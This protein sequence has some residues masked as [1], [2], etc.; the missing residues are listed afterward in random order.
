MGLYNNIYNFFL[1]F[2][3]NSAHLIYGR[4][5]VT[6]WVQ[7]VATEVEHPLKV[8]DVGCGDGSDLANLQVL[9]KGSA[10][11]YGIEI[12]PVMRKSCTLRGIP[13]AVI[14]IEKEMLPFPDGWLD[15]VILNQVLEHTKNHFHIFTELA[16]VLKSGGVLIVGVPNLAAWHDRVILMLGHQP[17]AIKVYGPH[18]RGFT[19]PGL[20]DFAERRHIFA[21]EEVGGSGFYPFPEFMAKGLASWFP[22]FATSLFLKLERTTATA[23][24]MDNMH[25]RTFETDY[26]T[27]DNLFL[28][29]AHA[30]LSHS[31]YMVLQ[32]LDAPKLE[33][34]MLQDQESLQIS[35]RLMEWCRVLGVEATRIKLRIQ[36]ASENQL[37][38]V[39]SLDLFMSQRGIAWFKFLL[40]SSYSLKI[41]VFL[42]DSQI[43]WEPELELYPQQ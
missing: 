36:F 18:V 2:K 7:D 38:L 28:S 41:S 11:L 34:G 8:L 35:F 1:R 4:H 23:N 21:T 42:K 29:T 37:E 12:D 3:E 17:S 10:T 40:L 27:G 6:R 32:G 19:L 30:S 33:P 16:R 22:T 26:F 43:L 31:K 39:K 13:T 14:D 9:L 20:R 15:V 24:F 5:L 25:D